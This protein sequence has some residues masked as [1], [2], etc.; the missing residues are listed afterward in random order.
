MGKR[1]DARRAKREKREG[2][3]KFK[4]FF[5]K[6]GQTTKQVSKGVFQKA[7]DIV[8]TLW[9][10]ETDKDKEKR[11]LIEQEQEEAWEETKQSAF[12]GAL[13]LGIGAVALIAI[14]FITK[15]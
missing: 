4:E 3:K 10:G 14:I 6:V 5:K 2:G 7:E 15:R 13:Y 11:E 8:D 1:R 9:Q 12:T